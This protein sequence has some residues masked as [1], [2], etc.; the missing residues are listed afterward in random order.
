M[1]RAAMLI[2][3]AASAAG[4][5]RAVDRGVLERF[6]TRYIGFSRQDLVGKATLESDYEAQGRPRTP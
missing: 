1:K 5:L 2:L 6:L 4:P 3:L